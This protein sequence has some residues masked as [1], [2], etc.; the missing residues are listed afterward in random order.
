[1]SVIWCACALLVTPYRLRTVNNYPNVP[2]SP[3]RWIPG[4]DDGKP[5]DRLT[6]F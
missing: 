1:M 5:N 6:N 3:H 2:K 4:L